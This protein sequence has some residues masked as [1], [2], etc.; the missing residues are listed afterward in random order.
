MRA[1][2]S[3]VANRT[4]SGGDVA[5]D[6]FGAA[7]GLTLAVS[8][9]TVAGGRLLGIPGWSDAPSEPPSPPPTA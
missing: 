4:G 1:C 7:L 3:I 9:A 5:L 8:L 6:A 2:A